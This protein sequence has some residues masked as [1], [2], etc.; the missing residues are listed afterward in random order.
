MEISAAQQRRE[1]HAILDVLSE[2][3]LCAV[4]NLLEFLVEP[5]SCSL[6]QSSVEQEDITAATAASLDRSR[7]SLGRGEG[8]PHQ[9]V[10]RE[11][12]A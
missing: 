3:K 11:F 8:I 4:R 2:Q 7:D 6:A 5:L 10:I 9:E 12:G 1:A